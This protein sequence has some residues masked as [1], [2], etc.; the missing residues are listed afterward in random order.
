MSRQAYGL[1]A[2]SPAVTDYHAFAGRGHSLVLD[3]GW[4]HVARYVLGWIGGRA[5]QP[6]TEGTL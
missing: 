4:R 5:H 2:N 1:Y 6:F 3:S